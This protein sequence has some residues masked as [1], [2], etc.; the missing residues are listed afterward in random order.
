MLI[1]HSNAGNWQLR[2]AALTDQTWFTMHVWRGCEFESRCVCHSVR[3]DEQRELGVRT[4]NLKVS[5]IMSFID[6][7]PSQLHTHM[8]A[9]AY[10][11]ART[12]V[13]THAH[14]HNP[15]FPLPAIHYNLQDYQS[16]HSISL[17]LFFFCFVSI[18]GLH[19]C[20]PIVVKQW[21]PPGNM[22]PQLDRWNLL[23]LLQ[24]SP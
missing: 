6:P 4:V 19:H 23:N 5:H 2:Y 14:T 10:T 3:R 24:C 18:C 21:T 1:W 12:H 8:Q 16:A 13:H 17:L 7:A 22:S 9:R 20:Q 11:H 15:P